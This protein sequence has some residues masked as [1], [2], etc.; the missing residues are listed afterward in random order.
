MNRITV[1]LLAIIGYFTIYGLI[2]WSIDLVDA[3][4]R[5]VN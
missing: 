4:V 1:G 3:L 2:S 5:M